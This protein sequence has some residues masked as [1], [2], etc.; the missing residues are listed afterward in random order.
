MTQDTNNGDGHP[1]PE[2]KPADVWR[3]FSAEEKLRILGEVDA[4]ER[5]EAGVV[6]RRH[7]IYSSYLT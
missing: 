3:H 6:L 4:Y 5:S 1:N 7:G 2:V